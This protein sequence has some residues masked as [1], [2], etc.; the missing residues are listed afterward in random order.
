MQAPHLAPAVR[1]EPDAVLPREPVDFYERGHPTA[2]RDIWLPAR[3]VDTGVEA[4]DRSPA[5]GEMRP[6]KCSVYE[7]SIEHSRRSDHVIV[8]WKKLLRAAVELT[9]PGNPSQ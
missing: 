6:C 8:A 9:A 5:H 7:G 4:A 2:P 1:A 3:E